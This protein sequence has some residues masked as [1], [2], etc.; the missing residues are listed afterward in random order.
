MRVVNCR[1][2]VEP[3]GSFTPSRTEMAF[4]ACSTES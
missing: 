3:E 4:W 1:E 2:R